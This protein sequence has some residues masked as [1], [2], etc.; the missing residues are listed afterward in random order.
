MAAAVKACKEQQ[1]TA[2]PTTPTTPTNP[3]GQQPKPS[4]FVLVADLESYEYRKLEAS[5]LVPARKALPGH[6]VNSKQINF[7][8]VPL[9]QVVVYDSHDT[10]ISIAKGGFEVEKLLQSIAQR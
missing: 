8:V 7:S 4:H 6:V 2:N 1:P 10:P 3:G 9:P 5:W